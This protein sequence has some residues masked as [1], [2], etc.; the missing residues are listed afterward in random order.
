M[1]SAQLLACRARTSPNTSAARNARDVTRRQCNSEGTHDGCVGDGVCVRAARSAAGG[2]AGPSVGRRAPGR[3]PR[4][5]TDRDERERKKGLCAGERGA[6]CAL[7]PFT[8]K[9]SG[10]AEWVRRRRMARTG[11][12]CVR[13]ASA[14]E[15]SR[16]ECCSLRAC[17]PFGRRCALRR[18]RARVCPLS[19]SCEL[20]ARAA[21]GRRTKCTRRTASRYCRL[22]AR[23]RLPVSRAAPTSLPPARLRLGRALNMVRLV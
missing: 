20:T 11:L 6:G 10:C 18:A 23:E 3:A 19:R 22:W 8:V 12:R 4:T 13:G 15:K 9:C 16:H 21:L 2:R 14:P 1:N 17:V 5:R 7:L